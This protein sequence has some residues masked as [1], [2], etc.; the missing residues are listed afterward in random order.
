MSVVRCE[1]RVRDR[2]L[3]EIASSSVREFVASASMIVGS[4]VVKLR[5][6][7]RAGTVWHG[8]EV[9]G[10][11]R[12]GGWPRYVTGNTHGGQKERQ[13]QAGGEKHYNNCTISVCKSI[14]ISVG[15]EPTTL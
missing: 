11:V 12:T 15:V 13:V 3:G 10:R 7:Y 6:Q 9:G 5:V 1:V 4:Q 8:I 14:T 2:A